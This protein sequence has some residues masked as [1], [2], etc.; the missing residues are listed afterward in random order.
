VGDEKLSVPK[1]SAGD[2]VHA[3]TKAGLSAI[4]VVGGPAVELFQ[5][6]LQ[7]PLEKRREAWM[8]RVGDAIAKLEADGLQLESLRENEEF[9]SVVMQASQ[10]A[11]RTHQEEKLE[12]LRNA[13]VNVATGQTTDEALH[14]MFLNFVDVF[15]V[16]HVR[17]LQLF[18]SPP[19]PPGIVTGGLSHVLE[20]SFPELRGQREFYDSVWRELFQRSLVNT[21]HLHVTMSG[22]GLAE[23]RTRDLATS[24]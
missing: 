23:K 3:V 12:M 16:W 14:T 2:L 13:V 11:I 1:K 21:E 6:V 24:F 4:P 15:T 19:A 22:A 8:A 18:Q 20:N 17:I 5:L 7:P 9:V 10:I